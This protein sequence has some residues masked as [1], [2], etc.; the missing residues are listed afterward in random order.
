M[1]GVRV[2]F[3]KEGLTFGDT[4]DPRSDLMLTVMAAVATFERDM[5][6][7]RQR[8]GI[9]IA[10]SKGVYKGRKPSLTPEKV[11]Q[12]AERLAEAVGVW[13]AVAAACW[14]AESVPAQPVSALIC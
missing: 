8:E 5:M 7:E 10:K 14:Q 1:D 2:R 3:V 9:A 4:S 13:Q 6:L 11:A 12:V